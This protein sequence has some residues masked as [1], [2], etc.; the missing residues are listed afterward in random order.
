MAPAAMDKAALTG[1]FVEAYDELK[2]GF[3]HEVRA[4]CMPTGIVEWIGTMCDYNVPGGTHRAGVV[5]TTGR[6]ND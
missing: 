6:K 1:A 5:L 3:L 4:H 2:E